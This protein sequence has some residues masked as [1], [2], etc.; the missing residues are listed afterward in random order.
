MNQY[1]KHIITG[2]THET[3]VLLHHLSQDNEMKVPLNKLKIP[4]MMPPFKLRVI[5][6]IADKIE[7]G[8]IDD[9]LTVNRD[10]MIVKGL[11]RYY[12]L[13]RLERQSVRVSIGL[14]KSVVSD[15]L[16]TIRKY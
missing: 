3:N 9:Q 16:F 4:K 11:K 7:A 10:L 13:K 5:L 8:E 2:D 12:A 15:E 14:T 1:G 6:N